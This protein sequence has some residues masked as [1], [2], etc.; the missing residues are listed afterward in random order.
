MEIED[1]KCS[2]QFDNFTTIVNEHILRD[3]LLSLGDNCRFRLAYYN[4][5]RLDYE[6]D[7]CIGRIKKGEKIKVLSGGG[8]LFYSSCD[9][10]KYVLKIQKEYNRNEINFQLT[11]AYGGIAPPIYEIWFCFNEPSQSVCPQTSLFVMEQYKQTYKDAFRHAS[12]QKRHEYIEKAVSLLSRL[13][14]LGIF[15]QDCH[16]DNFMIGFHDEIVLID[17]G[18]AS[19]YQIRN[20]FNILYNE[21]YSLHLSNEEKLSL[22]GIILPYTKPKDNPPLLGLKKEAKEPKRIEERLGFTRVGKSGGS[23]SGGYVG[24][25]DS[26]EDEDE[27]EDD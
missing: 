4:K 19:L 15:H 18:E 8:E 24:R 21:I 5:D 26:D 16:L 1:G 12:T 6:D 11:A 23:R 3:P 2:T 25:Q 22:L 9:D 17:Y 10:K 7:E 20:D 14:V 27:D 13:H